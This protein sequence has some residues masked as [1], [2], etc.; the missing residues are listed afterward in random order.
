MPPEKTCPTCGKPMTETGLMG[1]CPECLLNAGFGTID[2]RAEAA[3]SGFVPPAPEEL[4]PYFPDLEILGLLGRGGMGA[5]Y[6]ARQKR[7]DRLVAL[8]ILPPGVGQDPSFAERFEREAKALAQLHHPNIVTL[9]DS[10]QADGLFYFF[11][12]FVDGMTL[13]QLLDS[14]HV[15]PK[16]ALAIV[17]QICEALQFAHDR[18]IIHRDI[19]PENILINKEGRVKIADFGV[20][21]IV[22]PE[23]AEATVGA[24]AIGQTEAG[25][26]IGTPQYMAPE[27]L[28]RP[29]EVD[30]RADIYALGVVF[31]QMLTGE[32]PMGRFEPP[33][34]KVHIDVRLD[35]VV[36]RAMEKQPDLRYQQASEIKTEVETIV[37]TAAPGAVSAVVAQPVAA[38][39]HA[40]IIAPAVGLMIVGAMKAFALANVPLYLA[41]YRHGDL[42]L[43]LRNPGASQWS[44]LASLMFFKVIPGLLIIYGGSEM[45]RRRSYA[46]SMAAAILSIVFWG[47][48]SMPVG[49]WALIVLSLGKVKVAFGHSVSIDKTAAR[50]GASGRRS[51][52]VVACVILIPI[53]IVLLLG[54]LFVG[55]FFTQ[56]VESVR[57]EGIVQQRNEFRKEATKTVPMSTDGRLSLSNINGRIDIE[58]TS[59]TGAVIHSVIHGGDSEAV[60]LVKIDIDPRPDEIV[61]H[62]EQPSPHTGFHWP[63]DREQS[64]TVDYT[65]QVPAH[66]RL[67]RIVS[68]NGPINIEKIAGAIEANTVNGPIKIEDAAGDL[69]LSTVNGRI[70]AA[71]SELAGA[72][73]VELSDVNGAIALTVPDD[74]SATF[75]ASTVNGGVGSEFPELKATKNFPVGSNLSGSLGGGSAKVKASS[76]NGEISFGRNTEAKPVPAASPGP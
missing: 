35:E 70:T 66:T 17:P 73:S 74:A 1:L 76:V 38:N 29:L 15:S 9:Y 22:G 64:A 54:G 43:L 49:I 42:D 16:E 41:L 27:Q 59:G 7:L 53:L 71:M 8:K 2:T 11:M 20:A 24:P 67:D 23:M 45:R 56:R 32:L 75:A 25:K 46:W 69:K 31:Y 12:E 44:F 39:G 5:V 4:A 51:W 18:G 34:R 14:G 19:K 62:T 21:K 33:S 52:L 37:S 50:S 72:Q 13:R 63:W 60:G 40:I 57:S 36:L 47:I 10:G 65:I 58:G 30:H 26:V 6:K 68:V 61:I 28:S 3:G 48:L 55:A